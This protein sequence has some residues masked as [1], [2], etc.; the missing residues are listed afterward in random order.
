MAGVD[1]MAARQGEHD[2]YNSPI[3]NTLPG[4]SERGTLGD[5]LGMEQWECGTVKAGGGEGT[6]NATAAPTVVE[7]SSQQEKT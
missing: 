2:E 5:G 3:G 1:E 6:G 4:T 7:D